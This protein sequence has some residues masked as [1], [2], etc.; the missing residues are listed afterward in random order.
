MNQSNARARPSSNGA[1]R[2][3]SLEAIARRRRSVRVETPRVETRRVEVSREDRCETT[4]IAAREFSTR[5]N[6][7]VRASPSTV[8]ARRRRATLDM[9]ER[10]ALLFEATLAERVGRAEGADDVSTRRFATF[11]AS[12][13][14]AWTDA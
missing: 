3:E 7:S 1:A 12:R 14:D 2:E 11:D 13:D 6:P 9:R 10:D 8:R 4:L 5:A